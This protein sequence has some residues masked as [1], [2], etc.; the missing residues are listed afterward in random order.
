MNARML[1]V[2]ASSAALLFVA[3]TACTD[4]TVEPV[5][6]VTS[7]NIFNDPSSYTKFL[8]KLYAGL[9]VGGE[10]SGDGNTDIQGIDEGFSQYLR[11]YWQMEELPTDEAV[12]AWNDAGVQELNTQIWGSSNQFLGA[13]YS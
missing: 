10:T 2:F 12:I 1:T 9:A 3:A 11:L 13:M 8:A 5:S 6:T 4:T 7:A